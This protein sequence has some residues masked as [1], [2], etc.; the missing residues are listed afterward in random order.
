M[1]S[2]VRKL[3][4]GCFDQVLPGWV[5]TDITPHIFIARLP[6]LAVALRRAGFRQAYRCGF[7][8]GVCADVELADSRPE[9]L[10]MEAIK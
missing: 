2:G 3:H 9:S 8:Q 1:K 6:G 10:F 5:N 7:R 4:L